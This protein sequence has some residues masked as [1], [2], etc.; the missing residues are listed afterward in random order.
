MEGLRELRKERKK[1]K[2][3]LKHLLVALALIFIT[4]TVLSAVRQSQQPR[5]SAKDYFDI[6]VWK[7]D[8]EP[9]PGTNKSIIVKRVYLNI[10][11]I[12]GEATSI[13]MQNNQSPHEEYVSPH[14]HLN[15]GESWCN[16]LSTLY[17]ENYIVP[18]NDNGEIVLDDV[19][20]IGCKETESATITLHIPKD[21]WQK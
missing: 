12:G 15:K 9:N 6:K 20:T 2:L 21:V 1:F 18:I 17:F 19:L 10:T 5:P 11:A 3:K 8:W 7:V 4:L 13:I 16:D 14:P